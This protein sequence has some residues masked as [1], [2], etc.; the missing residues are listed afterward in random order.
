MNIEPQSF[1][2]VHHKQY[3]FFSHIHLSYNILASY[4]VMLPLGFHYKQAINANVKI[5]QCLE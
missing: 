3:F 1:G 4:Y 5:L 2:R